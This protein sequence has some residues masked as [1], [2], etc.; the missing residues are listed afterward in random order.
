MIRYGQERRLDL[1]NFLPGYVADEELSEVVKAFQDV[2][3]EMYE[4]AESYTKT[5]EI[6]I[7][8]NEHLAGEDGSDVL[9]KYGKGNY[10]LQRMLME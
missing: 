10:L 8:R 2:L 1:S 4:G 3:N 6:S 5:K 9:Y 7:S